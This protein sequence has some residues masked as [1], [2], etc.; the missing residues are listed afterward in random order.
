MFE[1]VE[2]L[3]M[4]TR[5][6]VTRLMEMTATMFRP[7]EP[8]ELERYGLGPDGRPVRASSGA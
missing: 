8:G 7:L 1:Q 5:Q 2:D 6:R 3:P 4:E